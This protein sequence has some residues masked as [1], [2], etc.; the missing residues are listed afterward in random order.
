[1]S[2]CTYNSS[3]QCE[4]G[5]LCKCK[6]I[7]WEDTEVIVRIAS[8]F[9]KFNVIYLSYKVLKGSASS[10]VYGSTLKI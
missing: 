6:K 1:M 5:D 10:E 7:N 8:K 4:A 3:V 9:V 2:W